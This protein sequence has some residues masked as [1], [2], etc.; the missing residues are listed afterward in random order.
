MLPSLRFFLG[1]TIAAMNFSLVSLVQAADVVLF[2]DA[3]VFDGTSDR[4]TKPQ[5][6]L[7]IGH[8]ISDIGNNLAPPKGATII[9]AKGL[10]LSPGFIDA[11][12][13]IMLQLTYL[14]GITT[15]QFYWAYRA[16]QSANTFLMNGFTT[17]RDMSGNS[18]SLKTAI[19]MGTVIGPRIFPS[20]P[21]ISQTSGHSD[22][23]FDSHRNRLLD[24]DPGVF[25]RYEMV[26]V[27]DGETEVLRATREALRRRASQIKISVGGGVSSASDPI[28]VIQYTEK[29]MRAAVQAASDYGTYVA[30]HAYTDAAIRRAIDAGVRTIEHGN[31]ASAETLRYMQSKDVW[32]SPQV[33]V[34][35]E[36]PASLNPAQKLKMDIVSNGLDNLFTAAKEVGFEN[37][38]FGTD[39]VMDPKL[40][41]GMNREFTHR[42][43]WFTPLEIM[44]QATSKGGQVLALSGK[45]A[46]YNGK[47][48]VIEKDALADILLIRGNPL[49][50][51]S[52][53]TKPKENIAL[54]MKD[55][56]ILKN[57]IK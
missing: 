36:Y 52:I 17:V 21:M 27:A 40:L 5:D 10:T 39:I 55:G 47:L 15:D 23:R 48:G 57:T 43:K 24:D 51:I 16:V 50:D 29:E 2:K 37:I 53:L 14:E 7:I 18:F 1:L 30:A 45:R 46:A 32:L 8:K 20:G 41:S 3:R 31:L 33:I 9:N 13:H 44:R 26:M 28:D 6:V 12:T 11:H 54:I 4:L 25:M 56:K 35:S 42:L 34:F 19:D 49:E 22:H 38:A